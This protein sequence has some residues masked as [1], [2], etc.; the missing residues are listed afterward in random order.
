VEVLILGASVR[1]AAFSARRAGFRT[2]SADLFGDADLTA[3]GSVFRIDPAAYPERLADHANSV[4]PT[5]WLYT[6]AIENRPELVDRISARHRL[7]GNPGR[8]LRAVRDPFTLAEVVKSAGL[9]APEVRHDPAG[10]PTDGSWLCKPRAS[11]GG[12]GIQ[13]WTGAVTLSKQVYYQERVEGLSLAATFLG[14]DRDCRCLGLSRQ[15]V[16]RPGQRFGYRGSLA[17]WPVEDVIFD[18]VER[19][20]QTIAGGF[21]LLGLFGVDLIL[22]GEKVYPIEVNPRYSA[23][24]EALEWATGRTFLADHAEVFGIA[25]PDRR[26][27][28]DPQGYVGKVVVFADRPIIMG[29]V[30]ARF[31]NRAIHS[32]PEIAD[33]PH[34]GSKFE[35]GEPVLTVL[36][37]GESPN[38]C[39]KR[40]ASRVRSWRRWLR[41]S[42]G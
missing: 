14:Q 37:S 36:A 41:T 20:G 13:G 27:S 30:E 4:E 22:R 24:I 11:G 31:F 34:P 5:A 23:S 10:L 3:I 39:R 16:G 35:P 26:I 25:R 8:V 1:A 19:L 21:G 29:E 33:I 38:D 17:P 2:N 42:S 12:R 32:M 7:L 18:Q 9:Q 40:L 15:F 6:G 28:M